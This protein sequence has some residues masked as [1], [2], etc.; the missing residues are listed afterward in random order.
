MQG[1]SIPD[2]Q[3]TFPAKLRDP[4]RDP[5]LLHCISTNKFEIY[6]GIILIK[7][8]IWM[9]VAPVHQKSPKNEPNFNIIV[10]NMRHFLGSVWVCRSMRV[11]FF[12]RHHK[13]Q[14]ICN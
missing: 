13:A 14:V 8:V 11:L 3:I 12:T 10:Q 4:F 7:W 2:L 9:P 6:N 1:I 5:S